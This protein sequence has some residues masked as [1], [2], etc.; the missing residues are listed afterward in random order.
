MN[1]HPRRRRIV[2]APVAIACISAAALGGCASLIVPR[3]IDVPQERLQE[4]IG[5][6]FPLTRRVAEGIDLSIGVP[7]LT[8]L[9]E[10]NRVAIEC[11]VTGGERLLERPVVGSLAVS[12][13]LA[14]DAADNSV[15]MVDVRVDRLHIDGMDSGLGRTIERL[16]RPLLQGLLQR[17]AIYA[18][19]PKDIEKLHE[20]GVVPGEIRVTPSGI[21]IALV[22]APA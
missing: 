18:L 16:A 11:E 17:Q 19:R 3:S 13:G 2:L 15:H 10:A 8:M 9:P 1:H 12:H 22:K 14:F 4:A 21:T 20:A 7:R 6:R 5:R